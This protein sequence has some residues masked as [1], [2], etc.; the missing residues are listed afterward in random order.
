MN[1][2]LPKV[3]VFQEDENALNYRYKLPFK[4][5]EEISVKSFEYDFETFQNS[6]VKLVG[7]RPSENEIYYLH[8]YKDN[9]YIHESKGEM[10]FLEE[11]LNLYRRVGA[12]LGAKS[13]STKVS[14]I[15]SEKLE[16]DFEGNLK[17]KLVKAE[18]NVKKSTESKYK[19]SLEIS[20]DYELQNNFDIVRNIESLRGLV[21]KY[22]LHHEL[23]ITSLIEA[24]D[25]R[26]TG[27]SLSKRS[28]K[29]EISSEYKNLLV[30]SAQLNTPVFNVSLNFKKSF[31]SL[32]KLNVDIEFIF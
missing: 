16:I 23:G 6:G 9:E 5:K 10:Y 14:L 24:R 4:L 28:V 30:V 25:S 2:K 21:D 18:F 29:S 32:N 1:N 17:V 11:K 12:L 19:D 3:L 31:E 20:E 8:P 26:D 13:I 7:P 27:V 22:N 15:E